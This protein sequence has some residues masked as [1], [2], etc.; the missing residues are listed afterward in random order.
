MSRVCAFCGQV[1]DEDR[2]NCPQCGA[3]ADLTYSDDSY[4]PELG[5]DAPD[6]DR[7]YDEFLQR[8][9]LGRPRK[10]VREPNPRT[11]LFVVA[12]VAGLVLGLLLLLL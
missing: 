6:E 2:I 9:G 7:E 10:R 11:L 12:I 5:F 3:D 4:D 1:Y 8:E